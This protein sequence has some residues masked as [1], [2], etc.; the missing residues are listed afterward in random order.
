M[1]K[2]KKIFEDYFN[3][4]LYLYPFEAS[5]MGFDILDKVEKIPVSISDEFKEKEKNFYKKYKKILSEINFENLDEKEK[6]YIKALKYSC[7]LSLKELS[8]PE[9]LLPINHF[10]SLHLIFPSVSSGL[11]QNF[12]K[13]KDIDNFSKKINYFYDWA[14]EVIINLEKGIKEKVLLPKSIVEKILIQL[15]SLIKTKKEKNPCF[16]CLSLIEKEY[17]GKDKE[18]DQDKIEKEIKNK[19]IKSCEK[20]YNFLKEKY[21]NKCKEE[22]GYYNLPNGIEWYKAKILR[23]T[24]LN[25]NPEEILEFGFKELKKLKAEK[26]I[27][28]EERNEKIEYIKFL[29][30]YK[31][32][33]KEKLKKHFESYPKRDFKILPVEKYKEKTFSLGEYFPGGIEEE[34]KSI[35]YLNS[36]L[37]K[38]KN[39]NE[40]LSIFFHEAIPGHHLQ[41]SLQREN[42]KLP[43][44][45]RYHIFEIF[46]EGWALYSESLPLEIG[47]VKDKN[48]KSA[49]LKNQIWRTLRLILDTGIHTGKLSKEEAINMLIK[50]G[51]FK[52]REAEIEILRYAVFPGQALTYKIGEKTFLN[53]KEKVKK[54]LRENFNLKE[55]HKILLEDGS[56]P[57]NLL[58]EKVNSWITKQK[59]SFL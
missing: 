4:W 23:Y 51:N 53:L 26:I 7:D 1:K 18:K 36:K 57:L 25:L 50:E 28:N 29:M 59:S 48:Y 33:I 44:F 12:K 55:F 35:F 54:S 16:A 31:E 40:I 58:K 34:S 20:I 32:K 13:K 46:V 27:L 5:L 17:N 19:I 14:E 49:V 6:T 24:T 47:L 37:A 10:Y 9:N 2:L 39:L 21:Q 22:I 8:F 3:E 38:E 43:S 45:L 56:L 41:I 30:K 11:N 42:K 15:E 52:N